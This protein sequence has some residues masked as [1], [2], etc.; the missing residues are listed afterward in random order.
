MTAG[1]FIQKYMESKAKE[2]VNDVNGVRRDELGVDA[3]EMLR[4][5]RFFNVGDI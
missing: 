1:E 4:L 3:L 5:G 2:L